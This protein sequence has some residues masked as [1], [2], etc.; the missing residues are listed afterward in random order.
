MNMTQ[1]KTI[2]VLIAVLGVNACNT[3]GPQTLIDAGAKRLSADQTRKHV[4]GN[5]EYWEE[6]P[7]YYAPDGTV[8]M[9]WL[10]IQTEGSWEMQQDGS[11]CFQV[12]EW[13]RSCHFYLAYDGK[14]T[15]VENGEVRGVLTIK[16]G[17]HLDRQATHGAMT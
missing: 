8:Q 14:I 15:T 10:R 12:P 4:S 13:P 9:L 3:A 16:P 6:G 1:I 7:V 17:K 2:S 5:T 11:I